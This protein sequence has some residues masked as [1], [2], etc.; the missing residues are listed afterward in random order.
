MGGRTQ[1]TQTP[2]VCVCARI[3]EGIDGI[4]DGVCQQIPT[5]LDSHHR[6]PVGEERR[7]CVC[8]EGGGL[9][10]HD[11]AH[12]HTQ[13]KLIEKHINKHTLCM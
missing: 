13:H 2:R 9:A 11:L 7:E 4:H 12:T 6:H 3:R 8:R 5:D 10:D 1:Y